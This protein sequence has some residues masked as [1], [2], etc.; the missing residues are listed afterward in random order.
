MANGLVELYKFDEFFAL[1]MRD[2]GAD[3]TS[4]GTRVAAAQ[5]LA[6]MDKNRALDV[7]EGRS[8]AEER[9][10]GQQIAQ[11]EQE[12]ALRTGVVSG[13]EKAIASWNRLHPQKDEYDAVRV[14]AIDPETKQEIE[15]A[16]I[17][18][19]NSGRVF[20][21]GVQ[22]QP[23][24]PDLQTFLKAALASPQNKGKSVDELTA[25]YNKNYA[26]GK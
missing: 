23:Q 12:N 1:L 4:Q 11:L 24:K 5:Q 14:K 6:M 20:D 8:A 25:F 26:G 7:A 10:K 18:D 16:V 22:Q 2:M 9:L 15:K 3:I 21:G 17:F 19:K 13:D